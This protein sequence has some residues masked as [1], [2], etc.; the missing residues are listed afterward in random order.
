MWEL[1][2]FNQI[3]FSFLVSNAYRDTLENNLYFLLVRLW[4]SSCVFMLYY[5][6]NALILHRTHFK[7]VIW[8]F[9]GVRHIY[10]YLTF[11]FG[12]VGFVKLLITRL[13]CIYGDGVACD[14][15]AEIYRAVVSVATTTPAYVRVFHFAFR[16]FRFSDTI[17]INGLTL[18]DFCSMLDRVSYAVS[19]PAHWHMG[20]PTPFIVEPRR[21]WPP[22]RVATWHHNLFH[23]RVGELDILSRSAIVM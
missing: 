6:S 19:I 9:I 13:Y 11:T 5:L 3:T 10:I 21:A 8:A 22:F 4:L 12:F 15:E 16:C 1:F 17:N 23:F 18:L 7:L 14:Y 2:S 20:I